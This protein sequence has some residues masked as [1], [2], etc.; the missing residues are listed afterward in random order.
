MLDQSGRDRQLGIAGDPADLIA[1]ECNGTQDVTG[2]RG[3]KPRRL[4]F[5]RR[6][7]GIIL[8]IAF[9]SEVDPG[10]REENVKTGVWSFGSDS[11]RTDYA[12][13]WV[14]LLLVGSAM[15]R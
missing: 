13:G 8:I 3:L 4:S 14:A 10:S 2:R 9:S 11:I 1:Q 7:S 6:A 12:L 15:S 5:R